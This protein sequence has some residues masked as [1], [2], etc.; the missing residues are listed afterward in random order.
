MLL[1]FSIT[2]FLGF[3]HHRVTHLLKEEFNE[4][5]QK[6]NVS[7]NSQENGPEAGH[8]WFLP[9]ILATQEA[10]I[11]KIMVQSQPL[12]IS[13]LYQKN[14]PQEMAGRV[15]Q[16]VR[17]LPSK[18]EALSSK[19]KNKTKQKPNKQKKR[20]ILATT[21]WDPGSASQPATDWRCDSS[22]R[23]PGL[24]APN[25][26]FKTPVL[27]KTKQKTILARYVT[28]SISLSLSVPQFP[29]LEMGITM[30]PTS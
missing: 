3:I 6:N 19:T 24:Q 15:A 11:E 16:V 9:I 13:S 22:G 28:L 29:H 21:T 18:Y 20:M 27:P 17:G 26:E 8:R 10:E 23:A 4:W 5:F 1:N 14:P 2:L 25:P 12:A 7:R 30:V